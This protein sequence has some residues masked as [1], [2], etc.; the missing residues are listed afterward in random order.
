MTIL[1]SL[2]I[3]IYTCRR[4]R[5]YDNDRKAFALR[6]VK[7]T[8]ISTAK[9]VYRYGPFESDFSRVRCPERLPVNLRN[10]TV[11]MFTSQRA[12]ENCIYCLHKHRKLRRKYRRFGDGERPVNVLR[13]TMVAASRDRSVDTIASVKKKNVE[14]KA[15]GA[16]PGLFVH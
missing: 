5:R 15:L 9:A 8:R 1:L 13:L 12:N 7:T 6:D 4:M 3:T 14:L 11:C 10:V 16:L 2:V